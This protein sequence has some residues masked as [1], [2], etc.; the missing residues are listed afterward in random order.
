MVRRIAKGLLAV[1][2][3]V[4][5][6]A[7]G[8]VYA[9]C[10]KYDESTTRVYDLPL[11][12]V[13]RSSDPAVIARGKHLADS[14][15]ECFL[16]HGE[17]FAGG[18]VEPL[19][20][21]GRMVIPN[22][23]PG[24]RLKSYSDGELA[25]LFRHGVKRDGTTVRLMPAE[26]MAWWPDEDLVAV[27]SYLRSLPP[28]EGDPGEVEFYAMGKVL[29]RV[30]SIPI[31]QARRIDHTVKADPPAPRPD[32]DYGAFIATACRG[33]HGEHLSGGP[34]PGGPP[35]V[36]P[37]LNLTPH[38]TGLGGW[39]YDDFMNVLREGKRRD[40]RPLN[41][42]MPYRSLRNMNETESRALWA[43]LQTVPPRPYGER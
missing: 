31:D 4:G 18:K 1:L 6:V 30:D 41:E 7:G 15:G 22:V 32:A 42:F 27:V 17:N 20:P 37:P 26:S 2:G 34:I 29:D 5:V 11:P 39:T 3:T 38:P 12:N 10:R 14:L 8:W 33:C 13:Q 28:V 25:R 24:G 40:G 36:P 21:L 43:Y 9:Q 35:G 19:G 23:T 16:C